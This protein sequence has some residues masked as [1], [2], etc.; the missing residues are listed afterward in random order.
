MPKISQYFCKTSRE[1][2]GKNMKMQVAVPSTYRFIPCRWRWRTSAAWRSLPGSCCRMALCSLFTAQKGRVGT[3]ESALRTAACTSTPCRISP[4]PPLRS[5]CWWVRD[6]CP[7]VVARQHVG[8]GLVLWWR[9]TH[10]LDWHH[11]CHRCIREAGRQAGR[12]GKGP[13]ASFAS[14]FTSN[15][16]SRS[17][18]CVYL[19]LYPWL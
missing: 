13:T 4:L 5:P 2:D 12:Q 10:S 7:T 9:Q 8:G 19:L 17:L 6:L 11:C 3:E 15:T 18:V 16:Q 1:R 14:H